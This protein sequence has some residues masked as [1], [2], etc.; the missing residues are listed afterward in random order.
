MKEKYDK[1]GIG[2]NSTR[3]ADPFL[4]EK[5]FHHLN[6]KKEYKYLD[7]GCGTGNYTIALHQKGLSFIGIEPSS[8]MLKIAKSRNSSI[9]WFDGKVDFIPLDDNIFDGAIATLTIHHWKDLSIGFS[10]LFRVLKTGATLV[11]FTAT[12][13]QMEGYWLRHYFPN[14]LEYSMLQMPKF[15]LVEKKLNRGGFEIFKTE[16]YFVK[17]DLK[18]LFLYAGK[19]NPELYLNEKVRQGISSFSS[20]ANYAE[21]ANGLEKLKKDIASGQISKIIESYKNNDGDYLFIIAKTVR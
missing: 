1:I 8:E 20:L 6:P 2:Y 21:V 15:E 9:E 13:K 18:D 5:L 4:I 19:H 12:P 11:I 17:P 14:M 3:K 10:E 7:I 16:K